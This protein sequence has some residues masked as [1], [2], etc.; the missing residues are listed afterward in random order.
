[1][2]E[3]EKPLNCGRPG[4]R[5]RLALDHAVNVANSA[6][7]NGLI[8]FEDLAHVA[9]Q[10]YAESCLKWNLWSKEPQCPK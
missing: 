6:F 4:V 9:E 7:W 5:R 10:K 2:R 1:M 3:G 8:E